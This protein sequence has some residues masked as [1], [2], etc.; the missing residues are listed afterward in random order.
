[1]SY[2]I[3][4][5]RYADAE[6]Q[7]AIIETAEAGAVA[8]S[9]VDTPAEW[10]AMLASDVKIAPYSSPAAPVP[11]SVTNFQARAVLLEMPGPDD[12]GTM[13]D[14]INN[15]L[16]AGKDQSVQGRINWQAWEQANDFTRNGTLVNSI[17]PSFGLTEEQL[18]DLFRRAVRIEA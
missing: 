9:A 13:F 2:T 11:F 1:M 3:T 17:G 10:E 18:D 7:S 4:S 5:A 14:A 16:A 8:I 15:A 12:Q 6:S